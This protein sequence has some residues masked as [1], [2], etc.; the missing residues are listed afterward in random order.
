MAGGKPKPAASGQDSVAPC[1]N[2]SQVQRKASLKPHQINMSYL[3]VYLNSQVVRIHGQSIQFINTRIF[4][5]QAP[6]CCKLQHFAAF[7]AEHRVNT[8]R[9]FSGKHAHTTIVHHSSL[10]LLRRPA[11]YTAPVWAFQY[12]HNGFLGHTEGKSG[13]DPLQ[14]LR[15]IPLSNPIICPL[16]NKKIPSTKYDLI[17]KPHRWILGSPTFVLVKPMFVWLNTTH[18][19][20]CCSRSLHQLEIIKSSATGGCFP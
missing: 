20:F 16:L 12:E 6:K 15:W 17:E 5:E 18:S 10:Y 3:A 11:T 7:R 1:E 19:R 13:L 8:R 4:E 2:L 14:V 9:L